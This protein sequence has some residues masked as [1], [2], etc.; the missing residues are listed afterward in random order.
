MSIFGRYTCELCK[1]ELFSE[2][3]FCQKCI[4]ELTAYLRM[5]RSE[6]E[7]YYI[8][9]LFFYEGELKRLIRKWKFHHASYMVHPMAELLEKFIL[10][11]KLHLE[12][13]SYVP[14]Y[15][16]KKWQ[17]GFDPMEDLAKVL[18]RR[19]ELPFI[20]CLTRLR[21]TKSLYS[22]KPKER[23][24]E[25]QDCFRADPFQL[26]R[27]LTVLDDIYTSGSTTREAAKALFDAGYQEFFFLILSR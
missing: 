17:R 23:E 25:L 10:E 20:T 21:W 8:Y 3:F 16:R 9:S 24:R 5:D 26:E 2:G 27:R 1:E 22:L 11:N 14:M 18:A 6:E 13:L 12:S 4:K 15:R 7:G 19:M